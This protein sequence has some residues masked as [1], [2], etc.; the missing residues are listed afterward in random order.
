MPSH[1]ASTREALQAYIGQSRAPHHLAVAWPS[2]DSEIT[3]RACDPSLHEP[4]LSLDLEIADI[5][6]QKKA[7]T[8]VLPLRLDT[9]APPR[10]S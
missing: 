7:N 4:N 2:T 8:S 10:M 6:N 1:P 5:I 3:E 9:S